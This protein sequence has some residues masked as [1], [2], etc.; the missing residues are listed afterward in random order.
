[1]NKEEYKTK[2][3]IEFRNKYPWLTEFLARSMAD[4]LSQTIDELKLPEKKELIQPKNYRHLCY[5]GST[6]KRIDNLTPTKVIKCPFK[7]ECSWAVPACKDCDG[8]IDGYLE[9]SDWDEA[10]NRET[11]EWNACIAE[12]ERMRDLSIKG[13]R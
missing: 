3:E 8:E 2:K 5:G 12:A 9:L 6:C 10:K 7:G 13:K 1:M 11:N 4:F